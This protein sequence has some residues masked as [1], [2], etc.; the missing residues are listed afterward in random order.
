MKK[1]DFIWSFADSGSTTKRFS[2]GFNDDGSISY[3]TVNSNRYNY[4]YESLSTET[5]STTTKDINSRRRHLLL[6]F[7]THE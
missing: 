4:S 3:C 2:Y 5:R 1:K 6:F 7:S